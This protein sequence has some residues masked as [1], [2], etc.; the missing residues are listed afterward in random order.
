MVQKKLLRTKMLKK[1]TMNQ[2]FYSTDIGII[3]KDNDSI[4]LK[5]TYKSKNLISEE[6]FNCSNPIQINKNKYFWRCNFRNVKI[7]EIEPDKL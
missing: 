4:R 1:L 7:D 3:V 2:K 6:D 5:S